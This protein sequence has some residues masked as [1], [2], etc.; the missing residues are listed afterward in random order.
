MV[1]F[2]QTEFECCENRIYGYR[3]KSTF[4]FIIRQSGKH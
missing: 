4:I 3:V 1:Y 2:Q